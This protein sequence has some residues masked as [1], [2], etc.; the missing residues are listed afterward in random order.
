MLDGRL[1]KGGRDFVTVHDGIAD[2]IRVD[3][4]GNV[5]SA[6]FTGVHIYSPTGE[7]IGHIP[8][9]EGHVGNLCFGG[10]DG[11]DLYILCTT[12][13]YRVRTRVRDAAQVLRA[14]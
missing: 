5:W 2:G 1:C 14:N 3:E 8:S 11:T 12:Q 9:P 13:P 4:L 10:D 6:E 7:Q